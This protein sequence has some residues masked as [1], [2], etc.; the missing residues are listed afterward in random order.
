[1][2]EEIIQS[3]DGLLSQIERVTTESPQFTLQHLRGAM[4]EITSIALTPDEV[5]VDQGQN[6]LKNHPH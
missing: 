2:N 1:M 6:N 3:G 4:N 5:I